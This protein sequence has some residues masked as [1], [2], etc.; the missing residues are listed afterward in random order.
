M[1]HKNYKWNLSKEEG[2]EIIYSKIESILKEKKDN[3][4]EIDELIFLLNLRT[5]NITIMNN[6]KKKN[7]SNFLKVVFGGII[8]F[9]DDYDH[10]FIKKEKEKTIVQI[11]N[12]E[13][14]DWIFVETD[15]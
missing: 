9:I 3:S 6:N 1:V 8:Q 5:K 10:F 14:S 11:N 7:I 13:Y 15:E 4:M 2:R 12:L